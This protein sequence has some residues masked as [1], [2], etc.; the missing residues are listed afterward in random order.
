MPAAPNLQRD[1]IKDVEAQIQE[2]SNLLQS[3]STSTTP[4]WSPGSLLES[5]NHELL[6][7]LDARIP[8]NKQQDLLDLF[9]HQTTAAWPVIRLPMKLSRIRAKS[10]ILLLAIL[11]FFVTQEMQGT[12]LD[13][14]DEL[15]QETMDILGNEV[16]G[17]GQI[18]LEHV[19]A[20]LVAGF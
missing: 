4:S 17:R 13:V 15:V 6:S 8:F 9:S 12:E 16:I 18:S 19:Q 20:L 2:L 1:R 7:F 3:Q 10:P 14:H 11:A 5:H